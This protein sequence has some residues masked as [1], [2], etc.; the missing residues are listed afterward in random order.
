MVAVRHALELPFDLDAPAAART[1]V[2]DV[3]TDWPAERLDDVLLCVSEIVTNGLLHAGPDLAVELRVGPASVTVAVSDGGGGAPL[4]VVD[5]GIRSPRGRGLLL[6][7]LLASAWGS[8][9][10]QGTGGK[11]VWCE[12]GMTPA[13]GRSRSGETS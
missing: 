3:L 6:V 12:V 4:E 10:D 9:V 1:F 8:S 2:H 7:S 11:T 13:P 5:A